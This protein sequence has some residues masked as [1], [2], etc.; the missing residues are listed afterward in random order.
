[1]FQLMNQSSTTKDPF[2]EYLIN[3]IDER[4]S[5]DQQ[6][7]TAGLSIVLSV[8]KIDEKWKEN[9]GFVDFIQ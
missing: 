5:H 9:L 3:E 1:M 2:L 4:F 6:C 8:M 7:V